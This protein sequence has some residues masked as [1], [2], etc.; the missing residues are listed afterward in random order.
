[1]I[2]DHFR[3]DPNSLTP[4]RLLVKLPTEYTAAILGEE[5]VGKE[6]TTVLKLTPSVAGKSVRWF[7][8]WVDEDD[9]TI[10]KLQLLDIGENEITYELSGIAM[11]RGLPDSTFRFTLPPGAE[12]LDLR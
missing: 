5:K 1:M 8:I 12:V 6:E 7:K 10:L 4:E 9:L 2:V 11:N 3:D